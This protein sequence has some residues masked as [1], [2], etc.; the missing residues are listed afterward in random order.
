MI[1]TAFNGGGGG[2]FRWRQQHLAAFNGVGDGLRRE[3][4]RAAQGQA[5]QQPASTMRGR[6]GG[7]TR[8]RREIVWLSGKAVMTSRFGVG[9]VVG[10]CC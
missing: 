10:F 6:E 7:A 8:G 5:T 9:L 3:D 1:E 2:G 4:K